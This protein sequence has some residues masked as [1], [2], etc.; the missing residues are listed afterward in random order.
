MGKTKK[1]SE[2]SACATLFDYVYYSNKYGNNFFCQD[3]PGFGFNSF[4]W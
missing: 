2:N 4:F 3:L 1:Q